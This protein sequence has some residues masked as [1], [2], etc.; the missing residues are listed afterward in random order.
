LEHLDLLIQNVAIED[1]PLLSICSSALSSLTIDPVSTAFAYA[2][3]YTHAS[4]HHH[5]PESYGH[6]CKSGNSSGNEGA[7]LTHAIHISCMDLVTTVFRR[8]PRHRIV[9]LE[10]L[11]PLFLKIPTSKKSIRTFPV[12][13]GYVLE[14]ASE[15]DNGFGAGTNT[16]GD[17][18]AN[19]LAN[20]VDG[21]GMA[22]IQVINGL[23]LSMI[24]SCV[25][26]P[27]AIDNPQDIHDHDEGSHPHDEGSHSH[28]HQP[29]RKLT[30][31]LLECERT[32]QIFISK[33][34]QRCSKKGG[35]G[36]ASEF[37]PVLSNL[38]EDL[39]LVRM[40]P[41][42]PAAE[43]VLM[44]ICRRL[45]D[46]L[47][48]N[49]A[50]GGSNASTGTGIGAGTG[51][52]AGSKKSA[53]SEATYLTTAMDTIGTI[54]SDVVGKI[55]L[56]K[57]N[58]LVFPQAVDVNTLNQD[59]NPMR[60]SKEVNR[61]ICGRTSLVD[62]FMLDCDRCHGWFHGKCVGIAKDKLPD[63]WIC[64][65]CTMQLM[66]LEQMKLFSSK[67]GQ[68][69]E[70][71][72]GNENG[73]LNEDKI[74]VMRVLLLNTLSQQEKSTKSSFS[75]NSRQFH[76]AKFVRDLEMVRLQNLKANGNTSEIMSVS[77]D[78]VCMHFLDLWDCN[79]A[80]SNDS[81][82]TQL[83]TST[84][85]QQKE[86]LTEEGNSKLIL[87]LNTSK[88]ELVASFPQLLGVII[89]LMGDE[90]LSS[91]RKLAV[92]ALSQ[93]VRVDSS[94]MSKE[95]IRDA[96]A[97]RFNDGSI[98]VREAV[99]SLVGSYV[100]QTPELAKIFHAPLLLRLNDNGVSVVRGTSTF[101]Q[102]LTN[103]DLNSNSQQ[104]FYKLIEEEGNKNISR[105]HLSESKI[106]W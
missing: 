105:S 56:A 100:L 37:R 74:H 81:I 10:D 67:Y 91:L 93:I 48:A 77:S 59:G 88:S 65:E 98:S 73:L 24:Q 89:L 58:P 15:R 80:K 40:L 51:T 99:V 22:Y 19:H 3:A 82:V 62:T 41:E 94:V 39:L 84:K 96:V 43:M 57:D 71:V 87:T 27:H 102:L 83:G 5:N 97:K 85:S 50:V 47:I 2:Y 6:G 4:S 44:Q 69:V 64:D 7:A 72:D 14:Y 90:N 12:K 13:I 46:D 32:C 68:G 92:K 45:C 104:L 55:R 35:E 23:L 31:G 29:K 54:C 70:K 20:R 26:M 34:I 66:V 33:L 101:F 49:S 11:F 9:I 16:G 42:Y 106:S 103:L 60:D 25:I 17:A 63:V 79:N 18:S 21:N 8:Y 78:A 61:C 76:I 36:G 75:K 1:Q 95:Q 28:S 30:S 52:G 38:V 53:S 86:C